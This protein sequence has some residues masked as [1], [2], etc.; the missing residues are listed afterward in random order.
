MKSLILIQFKEIMNKKV[1]KNLLKQNPR[2][3]KA[4]EETIKNLCEQIKKYFKQHNI[5]VET[6]FELHNEN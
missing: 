1:D 4:T 5:K 2:L 3:M 6:A